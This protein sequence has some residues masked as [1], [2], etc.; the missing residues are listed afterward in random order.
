MHLCDS[1]YR[2]L[3][4]EKMR[5][6]DTTEMFFT[7]A[8]AGYKM[9]GFKRNENVRRDLEITGYTTLMFVSKTC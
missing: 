8:V 4:G 6:M 1:E 2:M 5:R 9:T 7:I 3:P